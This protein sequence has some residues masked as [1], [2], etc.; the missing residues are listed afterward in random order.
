MSV[1]GINITQ[2]K[3]IDEELK[4]NTASSST[5]S[6]NG[7]A[8]TISSNSKMD[9][10]EFISSNKTTNN[11]NSKTAGTNLEN[12]E[13]ELKLKKQNLEELEIQQQKIQDEINLKQKKYERITKQINKATQNLEEDQKAQQ[14]KAMY[15]AL[16]TYNKEEHGDFN[17]YLQEQLKDVVPDETLKSLISGLSGVSTTLMNEIGVLQTNLISINEQITPL[18][19]EIS[20]LQTEIN[21]LNKTKQA[22]E[23]KS[24]TQANEVEKTSQDTSDL[25]GIDKLKSMVSPEEWALVE[26]NNIDLSEKLPNGEPRYI[27]APGKTSG[28]IHIYDMSGAMGTALA[29]KYS[30]TEISVDEF[31]KNAKN[32]TSI[33]GRKQALSGAL[34]GYDIVP[35]GDGFISN[36]RQKTPEELVEGTLW[37]NANSGAQTYYYLDDCCEVKCNKACYCTAS[38][39]NFDLDGDGINTT[40]EIIDFDIDGDG[41]MDKI[42]NSSDAV[43][44]FDADGDGISG[45]DGSECFGDNTDLDGDGKADGYKDGFEALKAL[46]KKEG[47]TD[48]NKLDEKDLKVL[49]GKYGLKIKEKGYLDESKSLSDVGITDINLSTTNETTLNKDFDGKQNDLMTQEGATFTMNGKTQ[50]YADLWH[51]KKDENG[52]TIY[53]FITLKKK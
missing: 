9:E 40:D 23:V 53:D 42:N 31:E 43:L 5:S 34:A 32:P 3:K 18:N 39:L 29:R 36:F 22:Q 50:N 13:E 7:K 16:S 27:F 2:A 14:Q 19:N 48:D 15:K 11:V 37:G 51:S 38:P 45:E 20:N 4:S 49:E 25:K 35:N 17:D 1:N 6:S 44:V 41:K 21:S 10:V 24:T 33:L 12:K 30:K 26:Q 47:L 8:F 46:A 28:N 52:E